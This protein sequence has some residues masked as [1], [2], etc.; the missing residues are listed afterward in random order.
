M[1]VLSV[2]PKKASTLQEGIRMLGRMKTELLKLHVAFLQK[3]YVDPELER[4]IKTEFNKLYYDS[5]IF[6]KTWVNT[7]FLGVPIQK[8]VSD[9]WIY[10][11]IITQRVPDLIIECG[12]A[13]GG[14]ALYLASLC[15]LVD[16]GEVLSIDIERKQGMPGIPEHKRI[17]YLTGSSTSEGIISTIEAS[18]TGTD[19]VMVILDS[20]HKKNHVLDELRS[21]Q[22]FVTKNDYMI[23]EDTN[24]NG[25]PVRSDFG[26]GP[27][28]AL[29]AFLRE[30]AD[31]II[32]R[33]KEKFL[34]TFNP[35]GYLKKVR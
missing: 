4:D 35:R 3:L 27:M 33:D 9:L 32:D 26:P 5:H 15:D 12:T 14:S 30:S 22:H 29:D 18:V 13:N 19:R 10:Q 2:N 34:V 6:G 11:E 25:H 8:C 31:F 24:I 7:S 28:E 1:D 20:D 23:V 21:Y 16:N 17:T